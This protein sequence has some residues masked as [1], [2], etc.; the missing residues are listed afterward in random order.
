MFTEEIVDLLAF[1]KPIQTLIDGLAVL[2]FQGEV[3]KL[4]DTVFWCLAALAG[5]TDYGATTE[6]FIQ[7]PW[8]AALF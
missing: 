2:D 1:D 7:Y 8:E 4:F 3:V 5:H 6:H